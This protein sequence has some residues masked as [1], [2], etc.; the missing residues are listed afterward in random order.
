MAASGSNSETDIQ[1]AEKDNA[2]DVHTASNSGDF[3]LDNEPSDVISVIQSLSRTSDDADVL[4][5]GLPHQKQQFSVSSDSRVF[6][7]GH[8][9]DFSLQG[10]LLYGNEQPKRQFHVSL[11]NNAE[12]GHMTREQVV[13]EKSN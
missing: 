4:N 1:D 9:K 8:R 6:A 5:S 3:E 7:P 12:K 2:D 13:E 11:W 10:M